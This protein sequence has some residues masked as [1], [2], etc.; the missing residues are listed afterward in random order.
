V[1]LENS[2]NMAKHNIQMQLEVGDWCMFCYRELDSEGDETDVDPFETKHDVEGDD[3][4]IDYYVWYA[5]NIDVSPAPPQD[6]LTVSCPCLVSTLFHHLNYVEL[7]PTGPPNGPVLFCLL[8]S[9]V[10]VCRRL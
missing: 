8:G 2:H 5:V 4:K 7:L 10:V 3:S 9:D 1:D 6:T